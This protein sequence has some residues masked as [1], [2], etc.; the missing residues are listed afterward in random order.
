MVF[1]ISGLLWAFFLLVG[2]RLLAIASR[3]DAD[4][5]HPV[6]TLLLLGLVGALTFLRPHE[7]LLSGQDPG[8]Y[9]NTAGAFAR[10]QSLFYVDTLLAEVAPANRFIFWF[11]HL[12]YGFTK[13]SCLRIAD[14]DTMLMGPRFPPA[15]PILLSPLMRAGPPFLGLYVVPLFALFTGIA[16]FAVV[17]RLRP[18]PWAGTLACAFYSLTPLIVWHA[19]AP[20]PE[21]I[22]G[23]LGLAGFLFCLHAWQ[24]R[25]GRGWPD[26]LLGA[27][28]ISLAPFFHITGWFTTV[29]AAAV[30]VAWILTGRAEVWLYPPVALLGLAAYIWQTLRI[31]DHYQLGRYLRPILAHPAAVALAALA[32]V[33]APVLVGLL[34]RRRRLP[35]RLIAP[36]R[37]AFNPLTLLR[38]VA[39]LALL[40]LCAWMFLRMPP[41]DQRTFSA[42]EYHYAHPAD[43]RLVPVYLSR[44]IA[45]LGLAGLITLLL[46]RGPAPLERLAFC[47]W[48]LPAALLI[49]NMQDFFMTRYMLPALLP[50]LVAG[51]ATL[52]TAVPAACN[53]RHAGTL[54]AA[55][56][57]IALLVHHRTS[58]LTTTEYRGLGRFLESFAT[59]IRAADGMLLGEYARVAAP[60]E[61]LFGIP[62]LSLDNETRTDYTPALDSLADLM[63]RHPGRP[64]FF[65]T[66]FPPPLSERFT[67]TPVMSNTLAYARLT[68]GRFRRPAQAQPA[69]LTLH[70]YR[71]AHA[72]PPPSPTPFVRWPDAGHLGL[73]GFATPRQA[74]WHVPGLAIPAG[75][76]RAVAI[77]AATPLATDARIML[78]L[79]SAAPASATTPAAHPA[80]EDMRAHWTHL[81]HG[82]GVL[83]LPAAALSGTPP[84]VDL[85]AERN[86]VVSDAWAIQGQTAVR[87]ALHDE[88]VTAETATAPSRWLQSPARFLAPAPASNRAT[89]VAVLLAPPDHAAPVAPA[90]ALRIG[91]RERASWTPPA[92]RWSWQVCLLAADAVAPSLSWLTLAAAAAPARDASA[93][94]AA[95][96]MLRV[97]CLA[98][99]DAAPPAATP[100]P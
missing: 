64:V 99:F 6:R 89:C 69:S 57:I 26:L 20:R 59:P 66:P 7:L 30:M 75:Q 39:A 5:P 80:R 86:L 45:G 88:S 41:P 38:A 92:P 21:I 28:C 9:L 31:A 74:R 15:F 35:V 81:G 71:I 77:D 12:G 83:N 44:A 46:A 82:W 37:P 24:A 70:L 16:L 34:A 14:L 27:L 97:A 65:L 68:P 18:R 55:L 13:D 11:G 96:P 3:P 67:F 87:L 19:R 78:F 53:R 73:A 40:A 100:A 90:F 42:Y 54:G 52:A 49:G 98:V 32:A 22:S 72:A 2:A 95:D 56:V 29:G 93:A 4:T 17:R 43:L 79:W 23:F 85:Q 58:M 51:L 10:H 50:M 84:A 25:A 8:V 63:T 61:H 91:E 36:D 60:F 1:L 33:I 76:R 94:A 62:L 47:V 48:L